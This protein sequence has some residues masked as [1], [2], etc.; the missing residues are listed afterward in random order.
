M[1][2]FRWAIDEREPSKGCFVTNFGDRLD[3]AIQRGERIRTRRDQDDRASTLSAE[4]LKSRHS[5][6]K[7]ELSE[8]VEQC[9]KAVVDRFPGFEHTPVYSEDGWGG[10]VQRLDLALS[11]PGAS[12]E[13]FSRLELLV[14]PLSELPILSLAGKGTIRDKE[15][16]ARTNYQRL[17]E[18]DLDSYRETVDLWVLEYAERYTASQ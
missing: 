7:I 1:K 10:R 13:E 4:E 5:A 11:K 12:K 15:V 8:Y 17:E 18:L 2:P 9:L 3:R 16:F 6:A 14:K